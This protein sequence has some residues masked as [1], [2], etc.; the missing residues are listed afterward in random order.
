[1]TRPARRVGV[2]RFCVQRSAV[3]SGRLRGPLEWAV[4]S[5][6]W[7]L[8]SDPTW[9]GT[10][11]CR[12]LLLCLQPGRTRGSQRDCTWILGLPGFRVERVE[13][14]ASDATS[15]VRIRIERCGPRCYPCGRCGQRTSR[16]RS[17]RDRTWGF[18]YSVDGIS[19]NA[20]PSFRAATIETSLQAGTWVLAATLSGRFVSVVSQTPL[21]CGA[22][23]SRSIRKC[24]NPWTLVRSFDCAEERGQSNG[25]IVRT[26]LRKLLV[27]LG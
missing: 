3:V 9:H 24:L 4:C 20:N 25:A 11:R 23:S 27:M 21:L 2:H 26:E 6:A 17:A 5:A 22:S 13:G 16:V 19:S 7:T 18:G 10:T 8:K 15:R 14:E 1:M 12:S